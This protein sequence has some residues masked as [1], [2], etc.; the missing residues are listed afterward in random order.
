MKTTLTVP[1]W[2]RTSSGY[3]ENGTL[4]LICHFKAYGLA[5]T[6]SVDGGPKY[7]VTHINTGAKIFAFTKKAYAKECITRLSNLNIDYTAIQEY[8]DLQN[9]IKVISPV[10]FAMRNEGYL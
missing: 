2:S 6:E 4:D 7:V 8:K 3:V 1:K 5:I 10:I 9:V